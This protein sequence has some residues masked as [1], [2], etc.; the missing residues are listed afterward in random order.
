MLEPAQ[1]PPMKPEGANT[2]PNHTKSANGYDQQEFAGKCTKTPSNDQPER[3][4]GKKREPSQQALCPFLAQQA[5]DYQ[6]NSEDRQEQA[7]EYQRGIENAHG[8]GEGEQ[9]N[10]HE[11]ECKPE[12]SLAQPVLRLTHWSKRSLQQC[13]PI[14]PFHS[15]CQPDMHLRIDWMPGLSR[16]RASGIP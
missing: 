14:G 7:D 11:G 13:P 12:E 1:N 8:L 9:I 2:T 6:T 15:Q 3:D 4:E 10:H 16:S 5:P